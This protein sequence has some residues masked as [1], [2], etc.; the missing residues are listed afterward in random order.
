[1]SP[2]L[3]MRGITKTFPGVK[4]LDNVNLAVQPGEIHAICGENGAGKSTLMKVLSGVYP[5]GSYT[6]DIVYQGKPVQFR[7]IRESE[8]LGIIIIHQEL[9]LVP[10]LSIAENIFLGNETS[11]FGVIDWDRAFAR[12]RELLAIVGLD[13]NP[14]T[15]ITNL[16]VGKQQLVEIAK[17]LSKEVKLLIL[18]EPTSSLNESDS[19]KL[20]NLLL[21]FKARGIS[22]ILISHKL[23]EISTVADQITIIRDGSSVE[24]LDCHKDSI[25]EDRIIKGMV[26]RDMEHRY[27]PRV[28]KIGGP[29]FEVRNWTAHHNVHADRAVVKNVNLR[30]NRGE[31]VGVAGLMGSGRTELAMSVFGRSYGQNISGEVLIDGK[32]V[33]VSTITRAIDSGIAY[34]TEDRKQ[35]GLV[36]DENITKNTTLANLPGVSSAMVIDSDREYT[37]ATDYRSKLNIRSYGV[38]QQTVNLSGGN[39]QKVVLSKWLFTKP[40]VL[41]LDEPTRGID[42]GAKYEIYAIINALADE[43]KGVLMISSEM[44]ELLGMCDRIYVMNEGRFVGEFTGAEASQEKIMRA[45][46]RSKDLH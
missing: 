34:V 21:G 12:T 3:E 43:G 5:H 19:Q 33:D 15:L 23:N 27:P 26:G 9:A 10:L 24:T 1:M 14:E 25:N 37:V 40:E 11:R 30:V 29:L 44:P 16:G 7:D 38:E 17:A 32:L 46:M 35:L 36:L 8:H 39:Q 13:E 20:L 42:V 22:S 4:A 28:P 6:G 31:I 18:D 45:I 41:I 2:I